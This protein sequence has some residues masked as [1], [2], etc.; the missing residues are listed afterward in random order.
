VSL[1]DAPVAVRAV[2]ANYSRMNSWLE[3]R[4]LQQQAAMVM[5]EASRTWKPGGAPLAAYQARAVAL[6]LKKHVENTRCPVPNSHRTPDARG[7]DVEA[8]DLAGGETQQAEWHI[9]VKRATE[10]VRRILSKQS[11]AAVAVLLGEREPAQVAAAL[12]MT[13]SR[14]Y[15]EAQAARRALR[16][17]VKLRQLAG[18]IL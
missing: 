7:V 15:V 12:G 10:E 5:I 4:E 2:V 3:A 16:G 9:D 11:P 8:I 18:A 1:L 14:V 6:S 17:S 13:A